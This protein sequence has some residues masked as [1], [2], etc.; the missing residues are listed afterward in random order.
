MA[1]LGDTSEKRE[2]RTFKLS[3]AFM[4]FVQYPGARQVMVAAGGRMVSR[5]V[6]NNHRPCIVMGGLNKTI[7]WGLN[8]GTVKVSKSKATLL[9]QLSNIEVMADFTDG[10]GVDYEREKTMTP[11]PMFNDT[12]IDKWLEVHRLMPKDRQ[13]MVD[14]IQAARSEWNETQ[15]ALLNVESVSSETVTYLRFQPW[16]FYLST[17]F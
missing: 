1:F 7:Y 13:G 11:L 17:G 12:V 5:F 10:V 4:R 16:K 15:F 8:G 14:Y 3:S 6:F 2:L 9:S